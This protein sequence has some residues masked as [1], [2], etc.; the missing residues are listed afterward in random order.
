MNR[1]VQLQSVANEAETKAALTEEK[2]LLKVEDEYNR[3]EIVCRQEIEIQSAADA[4]IEDST[5]EVKNLESLHEQMQA[6]VKNMSSELSILRPQAM[7]ASQLEIKFSKL[8]KDSGE[9][10][11]LLKTHLSEA[12]EK[13]KKVSAKF[14]TESLRRIQ[15]QDEVKAQEN[16]VASLQNDL[17]NAATSESNHKTQVLNLRSSMQKLDRSLEHEEEQWCKKFELASTK[18]KQLH[19][20]TID[21]ISA[22]TTETQKKQLLQ[23]LNIKDLN[24]GIAEM[25][26]KVTNMREAE[27]EINRKYQTELH[28]NQDFINQNRALKAQLDSSLEEIKLREMKRVELADTLLSH[29]A[30][31]KILS[32][33]F[34]LSQSELAQVKQDKQNEI[35]NLKETISVLEKLVATHAAEISDYKSTLHDDKRKY[36]S[37]EEKYHASTG[38]TAKVIDDLKAKVSKRD[39]QLQQ[40]LQQTKTAEESATS[41]ILQ[42]QQ[43]IASQQSSFNEL[44]QI[45]KKLES[46][47]ELSKNLEISKKSQH[48]VTLYLSLF[49]NSSKCIVCIVIMINHLV[50]YC[51]IITLKGPNG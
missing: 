38:K 25:E 22:L 29:E 10:V 18:M 32:E 39:E 20:M 48:Q 14:D 15:L 8:E 44:T 27:I 35:L 11:T 47:L 23:A 26:Q 7:A 4:A 28:E 6:N 3:Y 40:Q 21:R 24:K 36:M 43:K 49:S 5:Q 16:C 12:Q 45:N 33:K 9:A 42:L 37:L 51:V 2:H 31:S 46:D 50:V 17:Q 1:R 30:S 19:N 13:Y 41:E 34:A